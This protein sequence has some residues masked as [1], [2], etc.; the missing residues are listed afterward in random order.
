MGYNNNIS[1]EAKNVIEKILA[2]IDSG[3]I[4]SYYIEYNKITGEEVD[5]NKKKIKQLI[6][7]LTNPEEIHYLATQY[8]WDNGDELIYEIVNHPHCDKGTALMLYY[9]AEPLLYYAKYKDIEDV[10]KNKEN[11]WEIN[12][13]KLIKYIED[14]IISDVYRTS[15]FSFNADKELKAYSVFNSNPRN[16]K[17]RKDLYDRI[18]KECKMNIDGIYQTPN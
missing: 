12:S 8:N 14:K 2:I 16:P 3:V 11:N 18:P 9:L 17:F 7:Q 4:D 15:L 5:R 6:A 1:L 13:F 10:I